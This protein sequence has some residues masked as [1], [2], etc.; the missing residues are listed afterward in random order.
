MRKKLSILFFFCLGLMQCQIDRITNQEDFTVKVRLAAEP[1]RLH[2]ILSLNGFATQVENYIFLPLQQFD[3]VSLELKPLLI[4]TA[5]KVDQ[6]AI[7]FSYTFEILDRANWDDGKPI[8]GLDYVYTFKSILNPHV[9][10][11]PY[12]GYFDFIDDIVVDQSNPK[13]FT[14]FTNKKYILA[15]SALSNVELYPTHLYDQEKWTDKFSIKNLLDPAFLEKEEVLLKKVG[16]QFNSSDFSRTIGKIKGCGPY[17]LEEWTTGERIVLK[18]K[19]NWWGASYAKTNALLQ[20]NPDKII[21]K[22]IPDNEIAISALKDKQID[23]LSEIKPRSFVEMKSNDFVKDNFTLETPPYLSY[24]YVALNGKKDKLSDQKV[25]RALAHLVDYEEAIKSQMFGLSE[26][27]VGPIHPSKS[28]YHQ[29]LKPIPFDPQKAKALLSEAA[30][31]DSNKNGIL[32][33]TINGQ[34]IELQLSFKFGNS[35]QMAEGIGLML[36]EEAAKVGIDISIDGMEFKQLIKDYRGRSYDLVLLAWSKL[37]GLDDPK[38]IWHTSSDVPTGGNRTGFGDKAS[39][40]IIDT[41]R[42]TL[43]EEKRNQLYLRLQERIYKDQPYIFLFAPL[44]RVAF[45]KEIDAIVSA[46]RPGFFVNMFKRK[47]Q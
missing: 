25:R 24:Y 31:T 4:K 47:K 10:A 14:V 29:E 36:K 3:P 35:N 2:P 16:D 46:K 38:Q 1:D 7:G 32:D 45:N 37:P 13:K 33:K 41:L 9:A 42:Q 6:T 43:D 15:E 23:V 30:W 12:R 34:V 26:R 44:E 39:D 22:I 5:P 40:E 8:T 17:E 19:E 11:A 20:A 21:Y 28:F 27:V 18:K